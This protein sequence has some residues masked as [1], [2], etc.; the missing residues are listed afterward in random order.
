MGGSRNG[1]MKWVVGAAL[2]LSLVYV[3]YLYRGV[4]ILLQ[5]RDQQLDDLNNANKR[6]AEELRG[7]YVSIQ[8][9]SLAG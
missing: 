9:V 8:R 7:K 5:E 3:L 6:I 4:R 2:F 1:R